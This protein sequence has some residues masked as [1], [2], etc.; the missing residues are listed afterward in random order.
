MNTHF[1]FSFSPKTSSFKQLSDQLKDVVLPAR[2]FL[3]NEEGVVWGYFSSYRPE[4][5]EN[6]LDSEL[7]TYGFRRI[8]NSDC[9]YLLFVWDKKLKKLTVGLDNSMNFT[10]YFTAL[11]NQIIFSSKFSEIKNF[12]SRRKPLVADLD[13]LFAYMVSGW[14]VTEKTILEEVKVVP[15]GSVV[16]FVFEPKVSYQIKS[17]ID[18]DGFVSSIPK[19]EFKD[20]KDFAEALEAALTD[21]VARRL[22]KIPWGTHIGCEL[23]SGFDCTFIAYIMAKLIGPKNFYC[24]SFYFPEGYETESLKIIRKFANKHSLQLRTVKLSPVEGY[25][26]NYFKLWKDDTLLQLETDY[27]GDYI[28]FLE[29]YSPRLLFTGQYGDETYS[30]KEW[31]KIAKYPRQISYFDYVRWLKKEG[32]AILYTSKAL[33]LILSKERFNKRSYYPLFVS[34]LGVVETALINE[35]YMNFGTRQV[36]PYSDLRVLG[37]GARLPPRGKKSWDEKQI[38]AKYL[39]HIFIPEMFIPKR[40]GTEFALGFPRNQKPLISWVMK[41]SVLAYYG[42]IDPKKIMEMMEDESSP[43]Y[44]DAY[45]ALAFEYLIRADWY[46][47]KN[48]ISLPL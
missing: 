34:D 18:I 42:L 20:E 47:I 8:A 48:K 28:K 12:V 22:E 4:I 44:K 35:I 40:G 11:D 1:N 43:L 3:E 2:V 15:P 30:L 37:E 16:E 7:K 33:N 14:H 23:S 29:K 5:S 45:I 39:N 21:A 38:Y 13:G 36:S 10:C 32:Q 19:E 17:L 26:R 25:A 31:L 27:F 41:N 24:Y 9:D 6:Q 46:L